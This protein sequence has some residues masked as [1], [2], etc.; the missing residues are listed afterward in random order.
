MKKKQ[1]ADIPNAKDTMPFLSA[2]LEDC[3][4]FFIKI[5]QEVFYKNI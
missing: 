2:L 3:K 4:L 1:I 5:L